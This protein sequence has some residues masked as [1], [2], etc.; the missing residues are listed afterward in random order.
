MHVLVY[1]PATGMLNWKSSFG[2]IK[3]EN[4]KK[5]KRLGTT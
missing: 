3:G 5:E 4:I 2:K 1:V